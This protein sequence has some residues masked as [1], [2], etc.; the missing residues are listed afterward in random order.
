MN[1]KGYLTAALAWLSRPRLR[2]WL[3][4]LA[5]LLISAVG[6]EIYAGYVDKIYPI[7]DWLAWPMLE[8]YGYVLLSNFA[9]FCAGNWLL[10]RLGIRDLPLL[11]TVVLS[12]A[13]GTVIFTE[14][15][16]VAGALQLFRPTFAIILPLSLIALGAR[17]LLRFARRYRQEA[18]HQPATSTV[19]LLL[20]AVGGALTFII[21][22]GVL[23]PDAVN[24]DA[25]WCHLTIAQDY[26]REGRIV[27][28]P[29]DYSKNVPHLTSLLHTW[30]FLVPGLK[31]PALRWML[32]LHQEFA[33]FLWTLAGVAAT[34]RS[35]LGGE[36]VGGSWV[37]FYLFPII[38]VYDN[39]LGGAADHVAASFALPG[40]LAAN[41]LLERL[42]W[43]RALAM[44]T[45]MAGGLLTKYQSAYWILPLLLVV[46]VKLVW[47]TWLELR[48]TGT[49]EGRRRLRRVWL[50]LVLG[51]PLLA[52]PHFIKNWIFYR[53][54]V[55]PLAQ[56][57]FPGVH[58]TVE[59]GVFLFNQIF[60]D[61]NWVPKGTLTN[62]L[63]HALELTLKFSFEPHYSFTKN[64][65]A[66]G[67]LFTLLL[68]ALLFI[69]RRRPKLLGAFVGMTTL[70]IWGYTFNVDRNL[71]VFMPILVATTAAILVEVW[72]LGW[73]SRIAIAPVVLFQLL[74]GG[75]AI[76]YSSQDRMRQAFDLI[77]TGY[78]GSAKTR[79]D[80]FRSAF[81]AAGKAL[82]PDA[83]VMLHTSH[84]SLGIDRRLV[85]D[86][87]GFQGLIGYSRLHN[88]R[89]LF[90]MYKRI[91]L[92]HIIN[93]A[94]RP[95]ASIQ[96]EVLFQS[97]LPEL[98]GPLPNTSGFRIYH[99]P[100]RAPA[101]DHPYRVLTLGLYGYGSGVFPIERLSTNE[102]MAPDKRRYARAREAAPTTAEALAALKVDAVVVGAGAALNPAQNA[103]LHHGFSN[104]AQYSSQQTIYLPKTRDKSPE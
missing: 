98:D 103:Y 61:L 96:E 68:P 2:Y 84:I 79:F 15:M 31:Q 45:C 39:N 25:T 70:F 52:S 42:T 28:F 55:Y 10:G 43:Q 7:D 87:S 63:S 89:E 13:L 66:F 83:T 49:P 21:Y 62:K 100:D 19:A 6:V 95:A 34:V 97:L 3:S 30:G 23:S 76:F 101:A 47:A 8:L 9:W 5:V 44:A 56:Q 51:L 77:S 58:P 64:V 73:F 46:G 32:A 65:P 69:R 12:G 82:P 29:G 74:W 104:V 93:P 41:R 94:E 81:V 60:T 53:D 36:R 78:A 75:D 35:M 11:E 20:W 85:L 16:Y 48:K 22:L 24:Y 27:P 92:T 37:A 4:G 14:L 50:T 33:V 88:T 91:G 102:Y 90:D 99:L 59:N 40:L 67:A 71:Q 18:A 1:A 17:E 80:H 54:P 86:W 38:F 26:A 72:R 57:A